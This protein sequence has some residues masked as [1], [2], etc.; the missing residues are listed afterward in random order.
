[1]DS[2]DDHQDQEGAHHIFG[3][4]LQTVLNAEVADGKAD[5]ADQNGPEN[6]GRRLAE[7]A[8][9]GFV[10]LFAAGSNKITADAS[11]T[12]VE[13]P[14]ADCGVKHHQ[15]IAAD[16]GNPFHVMPVAALWL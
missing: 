11:E 7:H 1:M 14:A 13:H 16:D 9:K 15:Q 4:A 12:V 3:N 6:H 10:D 2:K 5:K 8:V